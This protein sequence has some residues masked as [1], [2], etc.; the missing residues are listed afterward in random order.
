[1]QVVFRVQQ[2]YFQ[3]LAQQALVAVAKDAVANQE[4]H[5]GQVEGLVKAG[6]RPDIDLASV[7]TTLATA[8]LQQI[9]AENGV[10]LAR[11]QL[12]QEM[13]EPDGSYTVIDQQVPPIAGEDGP[14]DP[15]VK[16]ALDRRPELASV[17]RA[18]QAQEATIRGFKGGFGP[19]LSATAGASE[20]GTGLDRLVPNW[21]VGATLTW[22]LFQG[23]LTLGQIHEAKAVLAGIDAQEQ[24][25]RLQVR[26]DVE[27]AQ[28]AV[29]AA[30]AAG[31]AS[32]EATVNAREQLR[33]AE[34][35]Y[36]NG[37]GNVIELGDAQVSFTNAA[38]QSVSS[39]YNLDIAR[40]QL[41]TALGRAT[42]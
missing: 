17:A 39:R 6:I 25:V 11:A 18:R 20:A 9:T 33:L 26:V 4:K 10:A 19:A 21:V 8:R 37:L 36:T 2:A 40:A 32:D 7:R 24:G 13:G 41:L 31:V 29:R 42:E 22:P 27:T 3:V 12:D 15:L 23:G 38:A 35:R 34:G 5:L 14:V 28:L 30:R 1:L 16:S